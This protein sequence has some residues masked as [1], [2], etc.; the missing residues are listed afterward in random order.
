MS[1]HRVDY[2]PQHQNT[3]RRKHPVLRAVLILVLAVLL[4]I[5]TNITLALTGLVPYEKTP[6]GRMTTGAQ[7]FYLSL[8]GATEES[9]DGQELYVVDPDKVRRLGDGTAYVPPPASEFRDAKCD[10]EPLREVTKLG[11]N[12]W[13]VP[14]L[15]VG[16]KLVV[17]E[18][19]DDGTAVPPDA[20]LGAIKSDGARVS[21]EKGATVAFGHVDYGPGAL[22]TQG[23]EF[24]DFGQLRNIRS[25]D[26]IYVADEHGKVHEFVTVSLYTEKQEDVKDDEQYFRKDG[27]KTLYMVTCSGPSVK[28]AGGEFQFNYRDN[29]IVKALPV[30]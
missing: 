17:S 13:R 5:V 16:N 2:E 12:E 14:D 20:P 10:M 23:G 29:L 25:C 8:K 18:S 30:T 26:H 9:D 4:F 1:S 19:N 3:P 6:L 11:A 7:H 24:S 22:S 15:N 21:D 27:P 28:D